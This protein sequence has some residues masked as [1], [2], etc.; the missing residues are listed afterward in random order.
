MPSK[1]KPKDR[2]H[3]LQ[4]PSPNDQS[5]HINHF[6]FPNQSDFTDIKY[7]V[8]KIKEC[9]EKIK[10]IP[11]LLNLYSEYSYIIEFYENRGE[12]FNQRSYASDLVFFERRYETLR[13]RIDP[14]IH[15][16]QDTAT[17]LQPSESF[18]APMG[19]SATPLTESLSPIARLT[20]YFLN[21]LFIRQNSSIYISEEDNID[22]FTNPIKND[23]LYY[24]DPTAGKDLND[25]F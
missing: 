21:H 4:P 1:N 25:F 14:Y 23:L 3:P 13:E 6:K 24:P 7:Y 19:S 10:N 15:N 5:R 22:T 17:N 18:I 9:L 11:A 12:D 2:S 16:L 20:I 8:N